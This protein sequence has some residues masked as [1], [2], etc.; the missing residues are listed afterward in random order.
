MTLAVLFWVLFIVGF[1]FQGY[2]DREG[3]VNSLVWWVLIA[4]LGMGVFG[5][6]VK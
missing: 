3:I 2:R 5:F 1:I 4:I 6:P